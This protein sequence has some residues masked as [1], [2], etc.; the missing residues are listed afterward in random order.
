MYV[1]THKL[2]HLSCFLPGLLALGAHTLPLSLSHLDPSKLGSEALRA[3]NFL[4][5]YDLR[6]LHLWAAEGL[7][8]TCWLMYADQP[9]G[10]A[11]DEIVFR[12]RQ[13]GRQP[14]A[15]GKHFAGVAGGGDIT[16]GGLW[17]D[18]MDRWRVK[19]G[20][21]TPPGLGFRAPVPYSKQELKKS[22]E[23]MRRDYSIA[24]SEYLLRPEVR[25]ISQTLYYMLVF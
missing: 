10:L 11:P 12:S 9:S 24:K 21:G 20:N 23:P 2:E 25:L 7:A 4:K 17:V 5:P 13:T 14:G 8:T 19:G 1:P 15:F 18:A 3:Y 6:S 22:A 16:R